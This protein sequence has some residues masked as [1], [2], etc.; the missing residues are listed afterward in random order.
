[1][2]MLRVLLALVLDDDALAARAAFLLRP[3]GLAFLDVL[4]AD[5]AALLGQ[6]R[7]EVRVP[8]RRSLRA[9]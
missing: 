1:M 4:E 6:D 9:A 2:M 8:A 3:D 7:R 5:E